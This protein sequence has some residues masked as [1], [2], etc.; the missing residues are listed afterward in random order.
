MRFVLAV[1][2]AM[3]FACGNPSDLPHV[4]TTQIAVTDD[5]FGPA[6][7]TVAANQNIFWSFPPTNGH[8]HNITWVSGPNPLPPNSGDRMPGA[9]TYVQFFATPGT[10]TYFCG[11]HGSADGTGMFG[12]LVVQ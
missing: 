7:D 5:Q 6:V 8:T 11:F 9:A 3:L 2:L 10:Y 4:N 1:G 12:T